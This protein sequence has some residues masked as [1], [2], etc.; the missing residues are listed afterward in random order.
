[1]KRL[2]ANLSRPQTRR[3]WGYGLGIAAALGLL[4]ALPTAL[5]LRTTLRDLQRI[6]ATYAMKL[7]WVSNKGELERRVEEQEAAFAKLEAKQLNAGQIAAFTQALAAKARALGCAPRSVRPAE[8]RVLPRPDAKATAGGAKAD[9]AR[10]AQAQF[11]ECPV[12]VELQCEYGQL[13]SLLERLRAGVHY[14]RLTRLQVR[15]NEDS[16]E[17][18]D[19]SIELA[20]YGLREQP[21]GN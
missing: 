12:R 3:Q 6:K 1:M 10:K 13:T 11:I 15:P 17:R 2:L 5:R 19:C 16:R 21:G 8:L 20:G 14:V 4:V 9:K 18:L 7:A